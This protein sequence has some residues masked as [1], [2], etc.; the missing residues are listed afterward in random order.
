MSA[1]PKKKKKG[2]KLLTKQTEAITKSHHIYFQKQLLYPSKVQI[3]AEP[4]VCFAVW[5]SWT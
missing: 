2:N 3:S 4:H 1:P 5:Q